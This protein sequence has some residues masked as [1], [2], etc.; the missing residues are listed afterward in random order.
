[1]IRTIALLIS[2]IAVAGV[3]AAASD[4]GYTHGLLWRIE[5]AS[6]SPSHL[7]GTMHSTDPAIATPGT[8]L[9]RVLDGADSLT[10]EVVLDDTANATMARAMLLP[11]GNLLGEIAG[12]ELWHRVAE[13]GARYGAPAEFLQRFQPWAVQMIFSLP[14]AELRRQ[15]EGGA[16]LDKV[17]Q[18][19]AVER[20]IPVHGLETV[21][22]QIAA[23]AGRPMDEQLALLDA[24]I[25]LN[26]DIDAIFEDL[27][28][29]YLAGDLAGM[30]RMAREMTGGAPPELI[31]IYFDRLVRERNRRMAD[32]MAERL[33]EG[34]A[35]IAVGALHLYGDDGVLG[36]LAAR[37]YTVTR[38]E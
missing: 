26:P 24:A 13:T 19:R 16:H 34:N 22:E 17:L 12:P 35:L 28:R 33:A 30:R 14:P 20:G 37:G 27:K 11:E 18:T 9:R 38:V 1:M 15:S 2:V 3:P 25:T 32:R 8:A 36:L 7:F 4:E 29:L 5:A 23:L 6:T 21:D 10:I 31:D